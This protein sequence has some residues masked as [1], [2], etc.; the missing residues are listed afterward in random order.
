[1]MRSMTAYA[2]AER[3]DK[4]LTVSVEIRS[5][6]SKHLDLVVR[7]PIEY[8]P[9]EEKV[10][11]CLSET[12]VRGRIE[13]R[14]Q[15]KNESEAACAYE[16]D[17]PRVLAYH[18]ALCRMQK[19]LKLSGNISLDQ[20]VSAAGLIKPVEIQR[21]LEPVWDVVRGCLDNAVNDLVDM[22]SKEGDFIERD[23]SRRLMMI[24]SG[25]EQIK[26]GSS[27]LLAHYQLRL[28]ERLAAL[29]NGLVQVDSERIAQEAAFLADKSDISEEIVRVMSH[30]AQFRTY[31]AADEPAGRKLNFLLQELNREFNTM[32]SKAASTDVSHL[33][34]E[35]KSEL[36]KMREQV[37]NIE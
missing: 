13:V 29:T 36:E 37:Q 21:D 5:Y 27:G 15:I 28:K 1:M 9:L 31:M 35:M 33:V 12:L 32:G 6:N 19:A 22:R 11:A 2:R 3:T 8:S 34:V 23:L 17:M 18:E 14:L 16:I 30:V 4:K 26:N 24:Q 10:K 7:I 20:M 25:T